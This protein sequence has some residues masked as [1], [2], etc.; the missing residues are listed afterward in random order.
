MQLHQLRYFLAV[1]EH[2]NFTEAAKHLFVAQSAVSQQIA[3]LEKQIGVKLF[4][5]NKRS[6]QL[7]KAGSVFLQ[8]A[9]EIVNKAEEA[10]EK[11]RKAEAGFIGR[12]KIGFLAAPVRAFLPE[13]IRHFNHKYPN[14]EIELNH[15]NLRQLNEEIKDNDL[16]IMFTISHGLENI[17][18]LEYRTLFS[19]DCCVFMHKDHPLAK[20]ESV[21]MADLAMEPFVLR[22]RQESPQWHDHT[23]MLCRRHGFYPNIVSQTRRIETVL[24]FVDAGIGITVFPRYLQMYASPNLRIMDIEDAEMIDIVVCR[25]KANLNPCIS[26]FLEE[27]DS[28]ITPHSDEFVPTPT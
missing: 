3:Y 14:I 13:L 25:K 20:N 11:A 19:E 15:F 18:G 7:T 24:M 21:H 4:Q 12:L 28:L 10:I 27:L 6:V 26:L 5:R 17:G 22:D 1:A 16:D 2:L 9:V 23:L 8:A